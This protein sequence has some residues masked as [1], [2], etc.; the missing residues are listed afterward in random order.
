MH[1]Y[2]FFPSLNTFDSIPNST[3]RATK[4]RRSYGQ[5][6][7]QLGPG[8]A[9]LCRTAASRAVV[10]T[11]M[12]WNVKIECEKESRDLSEK[13]LWRSYN[14][15]NG[16]KALFLNARKISR[17]IVA[18]AIFTCTI[19]LHAT[20]RGEACHWILSRLRLLT[21]PVP[22]PP[23]EMTLLEEFPFAG[24]SLGYHM[25]KLSL[26]QMWLRRI[27]RLRERPPYYKNIL[28]YKN[29]Y[30]SIPDYFI[31]GPCYLLISVYLRYRLIL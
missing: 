30:Y 15:D 2:S 25:I 26:S 7:R 24:L 23:L 21:N 29:I 10:S 4:G 22:L 18:V 12:T 8:S 5:V 20:T 14:A 9:V 3:G 16:C 28:W 6:K 27:T 1:Y 19:T 11:V 13:C 17:L 31:S